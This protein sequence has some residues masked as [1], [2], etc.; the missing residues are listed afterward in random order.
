MTGLQFF[1]LSDSLKFLP[2]TVFH[3]FIFLSFLWLI[4]VEE[5]KQFLKE[6]NQFL[7]GKKDFFT[8]CY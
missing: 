2:Q 3:L 5:K 4:F 8:K 7:K 6:K 1:R